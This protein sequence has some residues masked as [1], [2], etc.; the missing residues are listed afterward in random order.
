MFELMAGVV[1]AIIRAVLLL[2]EPE[3]AIFTDLIVLFNVNKELE[4]LLWQGRNFQKVRKLMSLL[5]TSDV[6]TGNDI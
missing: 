6:V 3:L 1:Q 2:F 5:L 4:V